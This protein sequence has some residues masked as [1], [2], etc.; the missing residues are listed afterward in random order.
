M[1]TT[2][3]LRFILLHN[4][5]RSGVNTLKKTVL[6]SKSTRRM[7]ELIKLAHELDVSKACACTFRKKKHFNA[8]LRK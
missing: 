7:F 4:T 1:C 6:I 3:D 2:N 5:T 8:E